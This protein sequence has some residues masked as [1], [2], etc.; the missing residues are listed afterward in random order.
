MSKCMYQDCG[1]V[2]QPE[3]ATWSAKQSAPW[4]GGLLESW[5]ARWLASL[6]ETAKWKGAECMRSTPGP[7]RQ[8]TPNQIHHHLSMKEHTAVGVV[9]GGPVVGAWVGSW[10][11]LTV[12]ESVGACDWTSSARN[13]NEQMYVSRLRLSLPT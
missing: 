2:S 5:T 4:W 9:V 8:K 13:Q 3:S 11:G 10:V 12:G 1:L 6:S 7:S